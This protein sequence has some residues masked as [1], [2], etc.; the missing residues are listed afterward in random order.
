MTRRCPHPNIAYCPLYHAAHEAGGF[1]C[2]D[3][4]LGDHEGC[5]VDRGA[6]YGR[7]VSALWKVRP[8]IISEAAEAESLAMKRA[9]RERNMRAAGL[10]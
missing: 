1:G 5:A 10:H 9:Q 2:D 8:E 3:G 4:R 6:D 7:M